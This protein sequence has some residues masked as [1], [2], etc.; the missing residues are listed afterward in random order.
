MTQTA[1]YRRRIEDHQHLAAQA[2]SFA[3]VRA[4]LAFIKAYRV[5]LAQLLHERA[6]LREAA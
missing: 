6:M 2:S 4:H 1:Y 5:R 3:A